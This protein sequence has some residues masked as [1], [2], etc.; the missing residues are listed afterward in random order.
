MFS[1][2]TFIV[3]LRNKKKINYKKLAILFAI[4]L[5]IIA[6]AIFVIVQIAGMFVQSTLTA[7]TYVADEIEELNFTTGESRL[8][9]ADSLMFSNY[10]DNPLVQLDRLIV[11]VL[12]QPEIKAQ[13]GYK[14]IS[15]QFLL[16]I[17]CVETNGKMEF[18][19]KNSLFDSLAISETSVSGAKGL[20]QIKDTSRWL[21]KAFD[22]RFVTSKANLKFIR[23]NAEYMPDAVYSLAYAFTSKEFEKVIEMYDPYITNF[24]NKYN[25]VLSQDQ[26]KEVVQVL[27]CDFFHGR[28]PDQYRQSMVDFTCYS[29]YL[30]GSFNAL[31]EWST[32]DF[33]SSVRKIIIGTQEGNGKLPDM[34]T[35]LLLLNGQVLDKPLLDYVDSM[36]PDSM[37]KKDFSDLVRRASS[38]NN[39]FLNYAYGI[40]VIACG[41][42]RRIVVETKL[43]NY[44]ADVTKDEGYQLAIEYCKQNGLSITTRHVPP[45]TDIV[46]YSVGFN[47]EYY[48]ATIGDRTF[49][50]FSFDGGNEEV[51]GRITLDGTEYQFNK[52]ALNERYSALSHV[53]NRAY[54]VDVPMKFLGE[55]GK[56]AEMV[57]DIRVLPALNE[58]YIAWENYKLES[59][60]GEDIKIELASALRTLDQANEVFIYWANELKILGRTD[61]TITSKDLQVLINL[62]EDEGYANDPAIQE[63]KEMVAIPGNSPHHTGRVIDLQNTSNDTYYKWLIVNCKVFGFHNYTNERWH[64]E[65]NP[66]IS[67]G[68]YEE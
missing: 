51:T 47:I 15:E 58:M 43:S 12:M 16:G 35:P 34:K 23:P 8:L 25:I 64:Y 28:V 4:E 49:P 21:R 60:F 67:G 40:G 13:K 20:Y 17:P 18:Q 36:I 48:T 53:I 31:A 38:T 14:Y 42:Y 44:Y 61:W 55:S 63:F 46:D 56:Y 27:A 37:I 24:K 6:I 41:E 32:D 2:A 33:H 22:S 11:E 68:S 7:V 1:L 39:A 59:G 29:V 54:L 5:L 10:M 57:I 62:R 65:Y 9:R 26:Y 66:R 19:I 30:L 52:I 50:M 3:M 45:V